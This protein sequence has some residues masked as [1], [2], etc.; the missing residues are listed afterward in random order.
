M[1]IFTIEKGDLVQN[2]RRDSKY[3]EYGEICY[4]IAIWLWKG[5]QCVNVKSVENKAMPVSVILEPHE[6]KLLEKQA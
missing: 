1:D 4:V 6:F 2:L 5:D 3:L